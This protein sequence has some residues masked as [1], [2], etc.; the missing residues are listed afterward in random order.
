MGGTICPFY[1]CFFASVVQWIEHKFPELVMGV[2]F[3]PGAHMIYI[4][5]SRKFLPQI[6]QLISDLQNAGKTIVSTLTKDTLTEKEALE[7]SFQMIKSA[8]MVYV[9]AKDGYVGK[10]VSLEMGYAHALGKQIV[11]SEIIQNES[12]HSIVNGVRKPEDLLV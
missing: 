10:T 4:A 3:P 9:F 11:S 2:R 6:R 12:I 5:G 8:D 7:L 1:L